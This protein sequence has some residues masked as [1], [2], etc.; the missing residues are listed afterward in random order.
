[1]AIFYQDHGSRERAEKSAGRTRKGK[2]KNEKVNASTRHFRS[3]GFS[4][5]RFALE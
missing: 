2:R 1:M 5:L 4:S 3:F